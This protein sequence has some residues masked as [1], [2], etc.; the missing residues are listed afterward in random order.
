MWTSRWKTLLC[1]WQ[2]KWEN[3]QRRLII[4]TF[5]IIKHRPHMHYYKPSDGS[6]HKAFTQL[7]MQHRNQND[8]WC[9]NSTKHWTFSWPRNAQLIVKNMKIQAF[10]IQKFSV[11]CTSFLRKLLERKPWATGNRWVEGIQDGNCAWGL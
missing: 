5:C 9:F 4:T 2:S 7:K 1:T 10:Q 8:T 6:K 3:I 11:S